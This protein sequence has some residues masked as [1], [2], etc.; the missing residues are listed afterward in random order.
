MM[1]RTYGRMEDEAVIRWST[2]FA[3]RVRRLELLS[4]SALCCCI[5]DREDL[6]AGEPKEI[7]GNKTIHVFRKTVRLK[8][9]SSGQLVDLHF[10]GSEEKPIGEEALEEDNEMSA[11]VPREKSSVRSDSVPQRSDSPP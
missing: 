3:R 5:F 6:H 2:D 4:S 8:P 1:G 9:D 11:G 7:R 10:F